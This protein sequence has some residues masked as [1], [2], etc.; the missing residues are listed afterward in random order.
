MCVRLSQKKA[1]S[2]SILKLTL[3]RFFSDKMLRS[4]V[5]MVTSVVSGTNK[6]LLFCWGRV[7]ELFIAR[8]KTANAFTEFIVYT[9]EDM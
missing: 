1:H 5:N 2:A 8:D 6:K 7:P 3:L 9:E 4:L